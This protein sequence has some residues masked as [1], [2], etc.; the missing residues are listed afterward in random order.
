[1]VSSVKLKV[2]ITPQGNASSISIRGFS[3]DMWA[4][5]AR[6]SIKRLLEAMD[7]LENPTYKPSRTGMK[8]LSMALTL[9]AFITLLLLAMVALM[10]LPAW[11]MILFIIFG[12][13]ILVYFIIAKGRFGK[14]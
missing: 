9:V 1:M 3:D 6:D 14:E 7:N 13:G 5:G 11:V 4:R 12:F 8:P 2:K 10:Y